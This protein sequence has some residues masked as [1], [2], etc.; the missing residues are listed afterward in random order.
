MNT[1]T[2]GTAVMGS[3]ALGIDA[4]GIALTSSIVAVSSFATVHK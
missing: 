2:M 1:A 3:L 4:I